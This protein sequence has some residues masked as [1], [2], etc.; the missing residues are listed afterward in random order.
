[1]RDARRQRL[2][3]LLEKAAITHGF[4]LVDVEL[5]GTKVAHVIRVFLDRASGLTIDDLA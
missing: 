4:E 5:S 2:I 1:M 3:D